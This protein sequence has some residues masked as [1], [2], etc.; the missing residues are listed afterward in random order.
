MQDLKNILKEKEHVLSELLQSASLHQEPKIEGHL[1]ISNV[2]GNPSYYY[3]KRALDN[4]QL[5]KKYIRKGD[6]SFA[7]QLAQQDYNQ[8]F[9]REAGKQLSLI[10]HFLEKY[11]ENK[12]EKLYSNLHPARKALIHPHLPDWDSFLED[13]YKEKETS[14]ISS[15]DTCFETERGELVR[16]KSEKII[17]DKYYKL[18][19]P[20]QYE[21]PLILNDGNR[22][23]I[24]HPDFTLLKHGE[25]REYYHEHFGMMDNPDY[26][27]SS[28]QKL[29]LYRENGLFEG[30]RLLVT[31]ESSLQPLK[32]KDLDALI[33][34]HLK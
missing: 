15:P 30:D 2:N 26:C 16:S 6:L 14:S 22:Q 34:R 33:R 1:R 21:K 9:S 18:Q 12:L 8:K 20:Y 4:N 23:I 11:D 29:S 19:I 7:S 28:L 27:K 13:W 24:L 32:T 5:I 31:F 10:R 3:C 25:F 17:A